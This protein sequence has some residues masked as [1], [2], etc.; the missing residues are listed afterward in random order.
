[1]EQGFD[2]REL[3]LDLAGDRDYLRQAL[4]DYEACGYQG[5]RNPEKLPGHYLRFYLRQ[6]SSRDVYIHVAGASSPAPEIAMRLYGCIAYHQDLLFPPGIH[7]G[8]IG[9]DTAVMNVPGG[10][11][12]KNGVA[13]L[14]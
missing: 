14:I 3:G 10:F 7:A 9:C 4:P 8:R 1:M 6:V 13:L 11:A 12:S 5:L 2:V